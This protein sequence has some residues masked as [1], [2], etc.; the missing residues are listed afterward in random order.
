MEIEVKR[1]RTS[2]VWSTQPE[3]SYEGT[4]NGYI[5]YGYTYSTSLYII[6]NRMIL[7]QEYSSSMCIPV[8]FHL[9]SAVKS[10]NKVNKMSLVHFLGSTKPQEMIKEEH[11]LCSEESKVLI[12]Y[13]SRRW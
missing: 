13:R 3:I 12:T 9:N 5:H 10:A 2:P 1:E 11:N 8:L 7:I 6:S 4:I